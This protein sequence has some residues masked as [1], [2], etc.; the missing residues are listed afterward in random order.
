MES[1]AEKLQ[2]LLSDKE[3]LKQ[4]QSLYDILS[5]NNEKENDCK[6]S[7]P[8]SAC[9]ESSEECQETDDS[10]SFQTD[11]FDFSNILRL[12]SLFDPENNDNKNTAL[13]IALKPHLSPQKQ[14]KVDKAVKIMNLLDAVTV[15]KETGIL[16]EII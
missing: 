13:L 1:V 14:Q 15:L 12:Q 11:G 6:D 2:S 9:E 4:L 10:C 16:S 8:V 5:E 7:S 3:G